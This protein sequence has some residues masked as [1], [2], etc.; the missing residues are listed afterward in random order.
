MITLTLEKKAQFIPDEV[1]KINLEGTIRFGN[2]KGAVINN[3]FSDG[4]IAG[5]ISEFFVCDIFEGLARA[6][7]EKAPYDVYHTKWM[8]GYE[9]RTVTKGGVKFCPSYMIGKGRSY[10]EKEHHE[11]VR[12]VHGYIFFDITK[13]PVVKITIVSRN[14]PKHGFLFRQGLSYKQFEAVFYTA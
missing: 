14:H 2:L 7:S 1:Y 12:N 5:L 9:C 8:N 11:K 10:D 4:R 13:M 3:I 6:E